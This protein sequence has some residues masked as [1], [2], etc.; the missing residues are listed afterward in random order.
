MEFREKSIYLS[1]KLLKRLSWLKKVQKTELDPRGFPNIL[2][3][4]ALA[5]RLL[6]EKIEQDYPDIKDLEKRMKA[7]EEQM[8]LELEK[9]KKK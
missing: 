6:N 8:I 5:E 7:L 2:T 1:D 9:Q 4:D 3:M